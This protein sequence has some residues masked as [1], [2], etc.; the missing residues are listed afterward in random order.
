M[1]NKEIYIPASN[2]E[3]ASVS[4]NSRLKAIALSA[5]LTFLNP[6]ESITHD[7]TNQQSA[8]NKTNIINLKLSSSPLA[9]EVGKLR[10][11]I[12]ELQVDQ[13]HLGLS[14]DSLKAVK[15]AKNK[16]L[17]KKKNEYDLLI[18]RYEIDSANKLLGD[19]KEGQKK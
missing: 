6:T 1:N 8:A 11:L 10:N 18:G 17:Q 12:H 5:L 16:E 14:D 19:D 7:E 3:G 4:E 2:T 9:V 13:S 15:D